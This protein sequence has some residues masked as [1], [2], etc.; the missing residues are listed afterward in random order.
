M[1][2]SEKQYF[3]DIIVKAIQ[4]GK[5]ETSGLVDDITNKVSQAVKEQVVITVNGKID[6]IK[7]DIVGIREH[8]KEQ[9]KKLD[10]L[11]P[12]GRGVRFFNGL[13]DFASY[14][15]P[16]GVLIAIITAIWKWLI[17]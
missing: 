2:E 3:E 1:K 13:R 12:V 17:K 9:D 14:V 5:K 6:G 11:K 10:E 4:S 16:Y 7:Q 8:L 15:A